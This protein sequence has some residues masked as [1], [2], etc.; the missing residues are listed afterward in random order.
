M[1]MLYMTIGLSLLGLV[2]LDMLWTIISTSGAGPLTR[3]T[4]SSIWHL[5]T[6]LYRRGHSRRLLPL[7]GP[8]SLLI[9]MCGWIIT[10]W[11]GYTLVFSAYPDDLI[12]TATKMPADV[13]ERIYFTGFTIFTLGVGD[14]T[15]AS[16]LYRVITAIASICG[17]FI[18]TLSITYLLPV[19]SAVTEKR[20]L[21]CQIHTLGTTSQDMLLSA[22]DGQSFKSIEPYFQDL[23][24]SI[25]LHAQRHFSYPVL[26]HFQSHTRRD[27][28]PP[29]I[30]TLSETVMLLRYFVSPELR[31]S[32]ICLR[33]IDCAIDEYIRVV[34]SMYQ[35]PDSDE[36]PTLPQL[37]KLHGRGIEMCEQAQIDDHIERRA[38]HRKMLLALVHSQAWDWQTAMG[39]KTDPDDANHEVG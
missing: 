36:A 28:F 15:P 20:A 26:H 21:A 14:I 7:L 31:P 12:L 5:G 24:A 3:I 4:S 11:A 17:L 2:M 10:L 37:H 22:W 25:S 29:Q 39:E 38:E 16:D 6:Y 30:A 34:R 19:L 9:T 1:P 32:E 18:V 33:S 35:H 8:A 13:W 23:T 27:A